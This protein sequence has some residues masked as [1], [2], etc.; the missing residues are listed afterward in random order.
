MKNCNCSIFF[1]KA[2]GASDGKS[3]ILQM[4]FFWNIH[5]VFDFC[6]KKTKS[7]RDIIESSYPSALRNIKDT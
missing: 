1:Y 6:V 2:L 7:I 3:L 4:A 5:E